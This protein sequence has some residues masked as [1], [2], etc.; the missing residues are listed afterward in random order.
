MSEA[1]VA[2]RSIEQVRT[3]IQSRAPE[4]RSEPSL[5]SKLTADPAG[6]E[7]VVQFI[8]LV[9]R[10]D[11]AETAAAHLRNLSRDLPSFLS[12][13]ER[14]LLR[15]GA[16]FGGMAPHVVHR[17][18]RQ[19]MREMVG[20]L[21]LDARPEHLRA[22]IAKVTQVGDRL[23][24]S[25]LG[26]AVLGEHEAIRHRDRVMALVA[27]S[28][29]DHV[30]VKVSSLASQLSPW[31][32][33]HS[34]GR[35]VDRL[36]PLLVEADASGTFVNVDMEA[37]RDLDLT[38][39]AFMAAMDRIPD[40]RAGIALQAYLPDSLDRLRRLEEWAAQ[41][42]RGGGAPPRVRIVKGANL[43]LEH[44]A[45]ELHGWTPA[46]WA[47]KSETDTQFKRM[48]D[49]ALEPDNVAHLQVGI[50]THNLFDIAHAWHVAGDR[51]VRSGVEFEALHGFDGGPMHAVRRDV[52]PLRLYTP[53]VEPD[54]FDAAI[55]YLVRRLQESVGV[56]QFLS[57]LDRL[58]EP[59]VF[60]REAERF[61][62]SLAAVDDSEPEPRRTQNRSD[63]APRRADGFTNTPDTDP[64]LVANRRWA[65]TIA[66]RATYTTLGTDT[67]WHH[68]LAGPGSLDNLV[69]TVRDGGR[70]WRQQS[71]ELRS[72]ILH[73]AGLALASRRADLIAVMAAET[74]KTLAEADVEV[75]EAVDFAHY[76]AES[77]LNLEAVDGARF[78]P[79]Q[80]CVV[81][82][83][84]NF[85][86]AIPAGATLGALAAGCG[87]ILKPAPQSPR[88][89][90]LVADALWDA[91]VPRD[92]LGLA[93]VEDGP[94]SKALITHDGVDRVAMTGSFETARLFRSWRPDLPLMAETSGKNAM[95]ITPSADRDLAVADLVR[96]AFG[97]AG[98]KCSAASLAIVVGAEGDAT[99]FLRQLADATS[100][101]VT[102]WATDLAT[103]V[104]PLVEPAH[105]LLLKGLTTLESG[106]HWLV[107]PR[108]LDDAGRLWSPG[109]KTGVRPGSP[110]HTGEYF[111]PVL[112]VMH[113]G[114]LDEAIAWQNATPFGLT[115]GIH[116][117]DASE[118]ARWIDAV[119]AG[120]LYV[121][122]HITGA[123][124]SRQP[125]GGWK[126]SA[127]GPTAKAGGPNYVAQFGQWLPTPMP[128]ADGVSLS[129]PVDALLEQ[130]AGHF[131]DRSV[132]FLRA[133]AASDQV[134][135]DA[136]YGRVI[137][138]AGLGA[139]RNVFRYLP[140]PVAIRCDGPPALAARVILAAARAGAGVTVSSA[141]PLP[142]GD[143][144]IES[145]E[146]WHRRIAT[147][148]P[149]R[150]RLVSSDRTAT[151]MA[152]QGDPSVALYADNV[153]G[154]GRVE[155]LPFLREQSI[156]IT[157]HRYGSATHLLDGV[158]TLK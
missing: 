62:V 151:A 95:V 60:A 112:G 46:P 141:S 113:A 7:F 87:T 81:A 65:E 126:R 127:V 94:L 132:A 78:S 125:F 96:G 120:N 147:E 20:H 90:A 157:N 140:T 66:S 11:D 105:D 116:S 58:D 23:N 16:R 104:G 57:A 143:H 45:A 97:N 42:V 99:T 3:W 92:A 156:S 76:Y 155:L 47:T 149:E 41:R 48:V 35:V 68:R 108:R 44:V 30:S 2:D 38:L 5:L 139:E 73:Q 137:D 64:A 27:R 150:I 33:D 117:L 129:E 122:R 124:V 98:Q 69:G 13:G 106:E 61:A 39:E 109:V 88:C 119:N 1:S 135:W 145:L 31:S 134:A 100:S 4:S 40:L 36:A 80:V 82:P 8:D 49:V 148:R 158:L 144:V 75:S 128:S 15:G 6:L 110:F 154:A 53:V 102:G 19:T 115:A 24:L 91:G 9:I 32:F 50:A 29:V 136:T 131:D 121:N 86:V 51:D 26:E 52:G 83:P 93:I 56:D 22:A 74:G 142:V 14:R 133:A 10:P 34:V 37:Y 123:I 67:V 70:A 25:L 63:D 85:P 103:T 138:T 21:V 55:A 17:R 59:E 107:E 101:L 146:A 118:V 153:T 43:S 54:E 114:T 18:A 77:L 152:L 28:D 79:S 84:W 89:A 71:P 130:W 72:W 111:G 12:A